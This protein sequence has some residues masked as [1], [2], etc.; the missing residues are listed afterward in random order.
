MAGNAQHTSASSRRR[1]EELG[2]A[3]KRQ[4]GPIGDLAALVAASV[5][6]RTEAAFLPTSN[7]LLPCKPWSHEQAMSWE[8]VSSN[9]ELFKGKVRERWTL[10][11]EEDLAHVD[12]RRERLEDLLEERYGLER[13]H[14]SRE[15]DEFSRVA[16]DISRRP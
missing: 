2:S 12:G 4:S 10:L 6:R 5:L 9:W 7:S 1:V 14:A 11:T 13:E 8:R 15:V 3:D 16:V